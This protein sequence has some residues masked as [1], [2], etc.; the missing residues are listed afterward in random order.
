MGD[1]GLYISSPADLYVPLMERLPPLPPDGSRRIFLIRHGETEWNA[2]GKMQGGGFDLEL[3]ENGKRQAQQLADELASSPSLGIVASSHLRRAQS[4]ANG[5]A[6][7]HPN[8]QR[9]ILAGFGEMRFGDFEGL[10]LRGPECSQ[11]ITDKF[12]LI[13]NAMKK[14]PNV[15]WPGKDGESLAEVEERSVSALNELLAMTT[16][17]ANCRY[18]AVVAHGRTINIM[19]ASLLENDCRLFSKFRQQ[20]CCINVLDI[21]P[22]MEYKSLIL[23]YNDHMERV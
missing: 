20:N 8:A 13:N 4:T 22:S 7:M 2:E 14:D 17:G 19:L 9:V 12:Q 23:N 6:V 1:G 10:S 5:I 3:N 11:E 15:R 21:S 18:I 16:D